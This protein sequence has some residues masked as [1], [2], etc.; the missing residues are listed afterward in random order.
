VLRWHD[1]RGRT[2]W[3]TNRS[4]EIRVPTRRPR[5]RRAVCHSSP[6]NWQSTEQNVADDAKSVTRQVDN[7]RA[8]ALKRGWEVKDEFIFVDDG[9]SGAEVKRLRERQRMIDLVTSA[10]PFDVIIMQAQDRFSRRD[11]HESFGELATLAKHVQIWFYA[12]GERFTFG[13]F[14]SNVTGILEGEFAAEY[15]RAIAAKTHEAM[16]RRAEQGHVTGGRTFGYDHV[17]REGFVERV[18]N[19]TEAAVVRDIFARYARGEGFKGIAHALN[20]QKVPSPRAQRGRPSGWDPGT[21]RAVLKRAIYRGRLEWDRTKKRDVSGE[22]HRGR[23]PKKDESLWLSIERPELRLVDEAIIEQVDARLEDRRAAYL[24]DTKGK[25][26]GRPRGTGSKHLLSGFLQCACGA[27]FEVLRGYLVCSAKR[28]KG[29][30][31]C[32][33]EF[34]FPMRAL[35]DRFLDVIEA[36][37][38]SDSFIE[39]L[40]ESAF[41]GDPEAERETWLAER[42]RLATEITNLTAVA[43]AGGDIAALADALK[44][45]DRTLRDLDVKLAAPVVTPDRDTLRRA[46]EMRSGEWRDILRGKHVEQGRLILQHLVDLPIRIFNDPKPAWVTRTRPNGMLVGMV[47]NVASPP[48]FEPGF[49]P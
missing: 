38:L 2:N 31:V 36:E 1:L 6:S 43:A 25:L 14:K 45:R 20:A 9:I 49:Q 3:Q 29:P 15:R 33:S 26:L 17:R 34:S 8:F 21:I 46:L 23:Q 35:E 19:H 42:K 32:T 30:S 44:T 11:G 4:I 27:R 39:S 28:R 22:R 18:I 41:D 10:C 37:L 7:A 12:K 13:D 47:R 48:G 24:R 16:R 40:L 5:G